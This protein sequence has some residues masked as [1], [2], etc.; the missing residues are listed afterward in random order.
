MT[1]LSRQ[2]KTK[3]KTGKAGRPKKQYNVLNL[4]KVEDIVVPNTVEEAMS[5]EHSQYWQQAL[6]DEYNSLKY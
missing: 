3:T 6:E 4:M 1:N 5:S 2:R